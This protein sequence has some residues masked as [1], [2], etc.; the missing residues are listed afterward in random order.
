[1]P[2]DLPGRRERCQEWMNRPS[3]TAS[4]NASDDELDGE[5]AADPSTASDA[6]DGILALADSVGGDVGDDEDEIGLE[7]MA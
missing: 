6:I 2:K 4:P 3:P 7:G 5:Q 1:M